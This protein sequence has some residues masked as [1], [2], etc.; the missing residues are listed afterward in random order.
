LWLLSEQLGKRL[1][2]RDARTDI[3]VMPQGALINTYAF[4][5]TFAFAFLIGGK[6]PILKL[7]T[8]A[9]MVVLFGGVLGY[10]LTETSPWHTLIGIATGILNCLFVAFAYLDYRTWYRDRKNS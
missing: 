2:L 3:R 4:L 5:F 1:N 6:R 10:A 8:R 9:L 7:S